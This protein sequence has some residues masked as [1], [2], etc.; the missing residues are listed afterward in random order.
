MD[1]RDHELREG[2][3]AQIVEEV[4][5]LSRQ[6]GPRQ[7][8]VQARV[9]AETVCL[10][11]L[12]Q[13]KSDGRHAL[14]QLAQR[15]REGHPERDELARDL[16]R[17]AQLTN[18]AAHSSGL[19]E[20]SFDDRWQE[21]VV[22]LQRIVEWYFHELQG[23][24]VPAELKDLPSLL[25][26][27]RNG[28]PRSMLQV[29][30][31]TMLIGV[32]GT[33]VVFALTSD[34]REDAAREEGA[35]G[36]RARN[37]ASD[38]SSRDASPPTG[39]PRRVDERSESAAA[40]LSCPSEMRLIVSD[41]GD[42]T[43]CIDRTEVSAGSY[44]RCPEERCPR[45]EQPQWG[46]D[47]RALQLQGRLCN[48]VRARAE[49]EFLEHPMNCV[50]ADDASTFCE[51]RGGRLPTE[52]EWRGVAYGS[53]DERPFPWGSGP[54]S[55]ARVNLCGVECERFAR[56][57][58]LRSALWTG[59]PEWDDTYATTAPVDSM[60][61]SATPSSRILHL[62]G[63]VAEWLTCD[64]PNQDACVRGGGFLPIADRDADPRKQIRREWRTTM[65]R[66]RRYLQ[67]GFRC[68]ADPSDV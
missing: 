49:E 5:E 62:A 18:S 55:D 38:L 10:A 7:R 63:N 17:V 1:S 48:I 61:D 16:E 31:A 8:L 53:Q 67:L 57:R 68:A 29:A 46:G 3:N 23:A 35:D 44:L 28:P 39:T 4:L 33:V 56:Q 40:A 32:L 54:P 37:L 43:F 22:P 59:I 58:G 34:S 25:K 41:D 45:H 11:V 13:P 52:S 47:R 20:A 36:A 12:Q 50:D 30:L 27:K 51:W 6:H 24:D 9:T 64:S 42:R 26:Q 19:R 2:F 65:E 66:N 60:P 14:K 15:V 21:V